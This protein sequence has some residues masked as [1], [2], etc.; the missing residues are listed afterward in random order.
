MTRAHRIAVA[1]GDIPADLILRG[2]QLVNVLAGEIHTTDIVIAD[3]HVVALESGYAGH[4]VIDLAGRFVCPGFIDAHVHIE[5]SLCSPPE[6]ARAVLRGGVTTAVTDPHE[7]ANVLGLD[8]IRYMLDKGRES[9]IDLFV[10]ASSCVPATHMETSGARLE[11]DALASLLS[12]PAVIGLAEMMNYPGVIHGDP[13]VLDKLA[14]FAGFPLDG[15]A[16]AVTGKPLNA[17]IAAGIMSDHEC[18][19]VAEAREKL[20]LGLTI[21]I[22]QGTT[23]QNLLALLPLVTPGNQ[24]RFCFCTDDRQPHSLLLEGSIDHM[25]RLAIAAGADPLMVIRMATINSADYF[26]LHDRG[27]VAPGRRADLV[28]CDDLHDLRAAMVFRAGT[29]VA[30]AGVVIAAEVPGVPIALRP[31][32]HVGSAPLD[33]R[34]AA[35]SGKSRVRVI[36]G[37]DTQVVTGHTTA[38]ATIVAGEAR[39]DP[40]RDLL[41]MAVIERHYGSGGIGLGFISGFGLQHGA[42]AGSVAHDHHN[43]VVIGADDDSMRRAVADVI[44]M[45]GGLSVADG[46]RIMAR[47]PLSIAGLMSEAPIESVRAGYDAL[48]AAANALGSTMHDPFMAMSFMALEVIPSLKLTDVGLVD[49]ERFEVV[50]LFV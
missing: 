29:L 50:D 3:G 41:K 45:G 21:F 8:G 9:M 43:I 36:V 20:R 27:A 4:E 40:A 2:G 25:V 49:V 5:S 15:H 48:I 38:E 6:Y 1:R 28:V 7:I 12:D 33:L 14:A 24:H 22:R 23:T 10:M 47:L 16:P 19:T 17:Y 13:S 11:A 46:D 31:T 30:R 42:I 35:S 44:E 37:S 26:R 32:M 39:T 34:I 18:T